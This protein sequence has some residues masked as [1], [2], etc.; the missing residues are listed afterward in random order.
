M[1]QLSKRL[2]IVLSEKKLNCE[3]GERQRG[4]AGELAQKCRFF[5]RTPRTPVVLTRTAA[6]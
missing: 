5:Q 4:A 3:V 6:K 2:L 1:S